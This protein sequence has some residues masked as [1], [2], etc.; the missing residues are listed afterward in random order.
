MHCFQ[1]ALRESFEEINL[2]P[3]AV[4]IWGQLRPSL[5][6]NLKNNVIP[7]VGVIDH[8]I[9]PLLQPRDDEVQSIFLVC[10]FPIFT[11]S[12]TYTYRIHFYFRFHFR[13]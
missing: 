6:R 13:I 12:Q 7:V 1:A 2:P 10:N 11:F 5:T 3:A 8:A 9:L 4:T